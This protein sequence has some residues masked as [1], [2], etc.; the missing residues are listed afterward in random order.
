MRSPKSSTILFWVFWIPT[1]VGM[2][3]GLAFAQIQQ[4]PEEKAL[5]SGF[6]AY[7]DGL[8]K[9]ALSYFEEVIRINPK[10]KAA[11]RG[12]E[13]VKIRLKNKDAIE[14][15]KAHQL[16]RAKY[17]EGVQL[18]RT[19]DT[20]AA[21]DAFHGAIDATPHYA[22]AERQ[23]RRIK[24]Q[25]SKALKSKKF[26]LSGW[27]FARGVLAYLERD[28]AKAYR[29]WSERHEIEPGTV[30]LANA[31]VRAENNFK[32]MMISEQEDFFRR[33]ARAYYEQGYYLQAKH[34]W[35]K[36][37]ALRTEDQEAMEGKAR[38]EEAYLA[39]I[40]KGRDAEVHDLLEQGLEQYASQN[41]SKALEVFQVLA[42]KDPNLTAAQEYI[43]KIRQTIAS[44]Q[45]SPVAARSDDGWRRERPSNQGGEAVRMP[46]GTENYVESLKELESQLKRDPTNIRIQQE[47]DRMKKAQEEECERIYKD[48][49]IAYSQGNRALAI[50]KWKQVL[51]LKPDHAKA[52][53]ALRKAKAEEERSVKGEE[54]E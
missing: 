20:V 41:W 32:T 5:A 40:G 10:S 22:P 31:T 3:A 44:N 45:Y 25:M 51:I 46:S 28:W 49:L 1:F 9:Q 26:N 54:P 13:K 34:S 29:I 36:V 11:Q 52:E 47:L 24:A 8:D 14:K 50:D 30:A 4:N 6:A 42:Q 18:L 2:T 27:A 23:I 39:A 33:G 38:A 43:A 21:I 16:A 7:M 17:K 48:G 15:T 35:D 19:K 37:L 53:A 12:L